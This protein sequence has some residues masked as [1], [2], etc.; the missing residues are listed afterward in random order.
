MEFCGKVE[1]FSRLI[2]REPLKEL[3][4][5]S[6]TR[7]SW[8]GPA[9]HKERENNNVATGIVFILEQLNDV[10]TSLMVVL[11]AT[12]ACL[13]DCN[14]WKE[15]YKT[16]T[17]LQ[18]WT[19]LSPH[20]SSSPVIVA[21]RRRCRSGN[22]NNKNS[23]TT[24]FDCQQFYTCAPCLGYLDREQ[25]NFLV[26]RLGKEWKAT[27]AFVEPLH[28]KNQGKS[29]GWIVRWSECLLGR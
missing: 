15:D 23:G 28:W 8:L 27:G 9:R 18:A 7:R 5:H 24:N 3:R 29:T 25:A 13:E 1:F 2:L 21:S 4:G 14:R 6:K 26:N 19:R 20:S 17:T 10:L 11:A 22:S 12:K 16:T